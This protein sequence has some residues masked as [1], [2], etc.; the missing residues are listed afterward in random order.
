MK[1][2]A[3]SIL[4][5]G[6]G[7]SSSDRAE[8][9]KLESIERQAWRVW[10]VCVRNQSLVAAVVPIVSAEELVFFRKV[11]KALVR[12][13]WAVIDYP[14]LCQLV[15]DGELL[16]GLRAL[17]SLHPCPFCTECT[18]KLAWLLDRCIIRSALATGPGGELLSSR[19]C[20]GYDSSEC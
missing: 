8:L 12:L 4:R 15:P 1:G 20:F 3:P 11:H 19:P 13:I 17:S 6:Y 2:T 18:A 10:S 9:A 7:V 14:L 5:V 16:R